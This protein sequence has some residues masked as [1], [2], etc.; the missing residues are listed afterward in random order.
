MAGISNV[1]TE[2]LI[3]DENDDFQ[4][5][6]A[7]VF[8][9]DKTTP[10]LNFVKMMKIKS[11]HYPFT[12]LNKGRSNLPGTHWW[13][14]LNTYP[15]KQLFLFDSYG[16]LGFT[17]FIEQDDG[18]IINKILYNTKKFIKKDN[19]VTLVTVTFSRKNCEKLNQNEVLKLSSTAADLFQL[20]NEFAAL[21]KIKD[22][23]I[24]HFIDDQLQKETSDTYRMF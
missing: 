21:N 23:I 18:D 10:F 13:S 24:S 5:N 12:I 4:R 19:I 3:E 11:S 2:E 6:F 8:P 22:E 1:T 17:V 20:I 16:F 7:G 9:S 15:K 14:I